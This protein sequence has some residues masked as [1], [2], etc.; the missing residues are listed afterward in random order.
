MKSKDSGIGIPIEK[1]KLIFEAF[2]QADASTSRKYGGTGLGLAISRELA[3]LLGGEIQLRSE[4][5]K[6]STFT[7]YIPL[8]YSF[9]QSEGRTKSE[10]DFGCDPSAIRYRST[11]THR[12]RSQSHRGRRSGAAHYRRRRELRPH[13]FGCRTGNRL[14]RH[15][16]QRGI[17]A[18]TLATDYN[19]T[20][21]SLDIHLPDILGWSVLSQLKHN[22]LTRHIPVQVVTLDDD[23][24]HG[25]A[26]GAFSFFTKPL[27]S[28]DLKSALLHIAKFST[29]GRKRLLIVEDDPI[30]SMSVTELLKSDDIEILT[31][32]MGQAAI[33]LLGQ[34]R[35]IASFSILGCRICS[36]FEILHT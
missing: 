24:H 13:S 25:L 16:R 6:G 7:L 5:G 35:S 1:Q 18:L 19:P 28:K 20:A 8:K 9:P 10:I 29:S 32:E 11:R 30:E 22:P 27:Q 26:R 14:E 23:R 31:A 17:D 21:I 4:P 15:H 2:Q 36:G 12:R 3:H 34:T 33:E